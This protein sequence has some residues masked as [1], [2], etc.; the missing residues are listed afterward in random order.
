[1]YRWWNENK[2]KIKINLHPNY[3]WWD[4]KG[5]MI[6]KNIPFDV[7][8]PNHILNIV[9]IDQYYYTKS[10]MNIVVHYLHELLYKISYENYNRPTHFKP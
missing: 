4:S 10:L 2:K 7:A 5:D 3:I 9:N 8:L 6:I 1:M